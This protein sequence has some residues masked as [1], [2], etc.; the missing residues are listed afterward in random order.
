MHNVG[1]FAAIQYADILLLIWPLID[2]STDK[3][4]YFFPHLVKEISKSLL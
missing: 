4:V 2:T 3:Y 1:F